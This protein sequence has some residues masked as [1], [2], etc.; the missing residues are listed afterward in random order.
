MQGRCLNVNRMPDAAQLRRQP[1]G[2]THQLLITPAVTDT[3]Q[4]GVAGMPDLLQALVVAPGAHLG[5]NAVGGAPESQLAQG[6]QVALAE[7]VLDSALGLAA[8]IDLALVQALTKIVRGQ[9]HQHHVVGGVKKGIRHGLPHLDPGHAAHHIVQALQM[10]HVEGGKDVNARLKQLIDILPALRVAGAGGVGVGQLI[11]QDQRRSPGQRPVEVEL[12]QTPPPMV[13]DVERQDRQVFQ[14][15][16]C[17][18]TAVGLNHARHDIQ[19]LRPQPLRFGEHSEGFAYPRAGPEKDL[20]P[21]AMRAAGLL[22]QAIGIGTQRLVC[23]LGVSLYASRARFSSTIFTPGS[24]VKLSSGLWVCLATISATCA[25]DRLRAA[26][27]RG[28]CQAT[29]A[30]DRL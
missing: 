8:H 3:E 17:L 26:A 2:G 10:L 7:K 24:P 25:A 23:H 4:D 30:G 29:A 9:V 6:D 18:L 27:T 13:S 16:R 5:V 19:P 21:A 14:H 12:C 22:Q 20:Q 1:R 15:R 11:H 28:I